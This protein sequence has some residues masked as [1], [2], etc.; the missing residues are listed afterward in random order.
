METG[1]LICIYLLFT[2]ANNFPNHRF[3]YENQNE[4]TTAQL[5]EVK[6]TTLAKI[7]CETG[8]NIQLVQRDVFKTA[9]GSNRLFKCSH[10]EDVSLE[11]WKNCCKENTVGLCGETSF[12]FTSTELED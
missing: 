10:I 9:R 12:F 8:D 3:W 5:A 6:K 1:S 4:F 11:P 2:D 7:I